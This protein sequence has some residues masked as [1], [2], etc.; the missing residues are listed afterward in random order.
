VVT[1][2]ERSL[3]SRPARSLP[4]VRVLAAREFQIRYR[5][6]KLELAWS[7]LAPVMVIAVYGLVLT[8]VFQ[9]SGG[10]VP[11]LSLVWTGMVVWTT[12]ATAVG[13]GVHA[14]LGNADLI[15]KVYF[16]REVLPLAV[17]GAALFDLLIGM[18]VLIALVAVQ[19][20]SVSVDV[21]W[22]IPVSIVLLVWCSTIA[23]LVSVTAVFL[24]DVTHVTRIGLQVGF[25]ATPVMYATTNLPAGFE[26]LNRLNPLAV[27][28]ESL[29][30][31]FL[32]QRNPEL[33]L[34]GVH[35]VTGLI[36]LVVVVA[37]THSV[38]DRMIDVI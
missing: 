8:R 16:P 19:M 21:L 10:G 28:I 30:A 1:S 7:L 12:F 27:C 14:L 15:S 13:G 5:Q 24:R 26:L 35:A 17:V 33:D 6:S 18:T 36:A 32:F 34:L 3:R 23:I 38:E 4:L 37:Y 2:A 9:A 29:R 22:A 20:G 31:A 25:F 11:Y